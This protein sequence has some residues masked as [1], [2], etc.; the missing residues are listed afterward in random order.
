MDQGSLTRLQMKS[1]APSNL[2]RIIRINQ[3][4]SME[5]D[6]GRQ[7]RHHTTYRDFVLQDDALEG[8][9]TSRTPSS[10]EPETGSGLSPGA[11]IGRVGCENFL[12]MPPTRETTPISIAVV[13][14]GKY[15][16]RVFTRCKQPHHPKGPHR[17]LKPTLIGPGR[18]KG[19]QRSTSRFDAS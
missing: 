2:E 10:P 11:D 15:R 3:Q 19:E 16:Y 12:K 18:G 6:V 5:N 7:P 4:F 8:V 1:S 9:M 14:V 13:N 17:S